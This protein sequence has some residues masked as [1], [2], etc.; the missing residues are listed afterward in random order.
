MEWRQR[1][2]QE[3]PRDEIPAFLTDLQALVAALRDGVPWE[4]LLTPRLRAHASLVVAYLDPGPKRAAVEA[5]LR[6]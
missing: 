2:K 5:A 3:V 6:A 4:P 1:L